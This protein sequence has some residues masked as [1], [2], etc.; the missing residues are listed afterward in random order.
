MSRRRR[1]RPALT[2][3]CYRLVERH[4]I[5]VRNGAFWQSFDFEANQG[6]QSIF[7][8]PFGFVAGGSEAIF[9]LPN[10]MLGYIIADG[11][12]NIV[13]D[14]DILLD[15]SQNNFRAVTAVSCSNCHSTGF[16][17]VVDEVGPVALANARD[18]GLNRDEVE[19]LQA[20]YVSPDEFARQTQEDSSSFYQRALQLADLPTQGADPVSASWLRF[21]QDIRL[22]D[23]A[24][25]LGLPPDELLD[26]VDLLNPVISVLKKGTLD[27]DDFTAL[28]VDSLCRLSGPLNNQPVQAVCDAAAAAAAQ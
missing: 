15:T 3:R 7:A 12:D 14:S 20:I 13:E 2:T 11:N 23:A 17:P 28:Y 6:N 5:Q 22:E 10:G 4:D 21:D 24:G 18:L 9:T 25:D 19:E 26:N 1:P 27:R 8:D 16:I